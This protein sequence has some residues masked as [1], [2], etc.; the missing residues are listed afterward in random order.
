MQFIANVQLSWVLRHAAGESFPSEW[1]PILWL[2]STDDPKLARA[3]DAGRVGEG[4]GATLSGCLQQQPQRQSPG[5]NEFD[6][7]WTAW[8][9][10]D[11]E[12]SVELNSVLQTQL[13]RIDCDNDETFSKHRF[14]WLILDCQIDSQH[15]WTDCSIVKTSETDTGDFDTRPIVFLLRIRQV[16]ETNTVGLLLLDRFTLNELLLQV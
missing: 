1:R 16:R 5:I 6:R 14:K 3:L 13:F 15:S 10:S 11:S 7:H 9:F 8:P 4:A 2:L 12:D